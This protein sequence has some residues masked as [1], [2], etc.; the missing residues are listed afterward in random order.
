MFVWDESLSVHDP[1]IDAQHQMFIEKINELLKAEDAA[2][3]EEKIAEM[4]QFLHDYARRHFYDEE[5]LMKLYEFPDLEEHALIHM[6]FVVQIE[7]LPREQLSQFMG[8]WLVNHIQTMDKAI[9]EFITSQGL[10][11]E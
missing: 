9:G 4:I 2:I 7:T 10:G 11:V 8:N 5:S 6:K 3:G 1:M